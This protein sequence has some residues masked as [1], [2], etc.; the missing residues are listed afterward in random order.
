MK[1]MTFVL[2]IFILA[3]VWAG[4]INAE[5]YH[6]RHRCK[7]G[8]GMGIEGG[9]VTTLDRL[10]LSDDQARTVASILNNHKKEIREIRTDL[11]QARENLMTEIGSEQYSEAAVREAA[12]KVA[13]HKEQ[14]IVLCAKTFN[15]IKSHLTA[16]QKNLM[17]SFRCTREGRRKHRLNAGPAGLD[18]WIASHSR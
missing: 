11:L 1:R 15:E 14:L 3:F 18:D 13:Q 7:G 10:N 17:K 5:A 4:A 8:P 6:G 12:Q 16:E 9:F 2:P